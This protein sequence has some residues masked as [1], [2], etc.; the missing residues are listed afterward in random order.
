MESGANV[1]VAVAQVKATHNELIQAAKKLHS[2][3]TTALE[4][5][6][7]LKEQALPEANTML[8]SA[9]SRFSLGDASLTEILPIRREWAEVQLN[10]LEVL[11]E[12]ALSWAKLIPYL[13]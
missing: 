4:R 1:E 9:E 7:V 2:Q 12:A 6:V 5:A 10:Y 8:K 11:K 13:Q 3:L